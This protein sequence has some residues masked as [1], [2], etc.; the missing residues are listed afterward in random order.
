MPV[1]L[2][3]KMQK[4][5]LSRNHTGWTLTSQCVFSKN[6]VQV[7][8]PKS[9]QR[10]EEKWLLEA[11]Y[12]HVIC[13]LALCRI[14]HNGCDASKHLHRCGKLTIGSVICPSRARHFSHV[15]AF[16]QVRCCRNFALVNTCFMRINQWPCD[17]V[18]HTAFT[19]VLSVRR[20]H[21][22]ELRS[23]VW[24]DRW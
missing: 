18:S 13:V 23:T 8:A 17:L 11:L 19:L 7:M 2:V 4:G 6:G 3:W 24:I 20:T 10:Y 14:S 15:L 5:I 21:H 12:I 9:T 22:V 16:W 1:R